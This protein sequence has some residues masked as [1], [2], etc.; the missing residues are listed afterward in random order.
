MLVLAGCGDDPQPKPRE[1]EVRLGTDPGPPAR[2]DPTTE[3]STEEPPPPR[4]VVEKPPIQ[5]ALIPFSEQ[6]RRETEQYAQRHYGRASAELEPRA[7]VEHFSVT[8]TAAGV[9]DLFSRDV[10]DVELHELP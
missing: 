6:R 3:R 2:H 7:I 9:R 1:P 5:K 8:P 10:P 4:P